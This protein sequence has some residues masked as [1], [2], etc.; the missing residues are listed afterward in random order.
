MFRSFYEVY[1]EVGDGFLD[2]GRKPEFKTFIICVN[3][4]LNN[5]NEII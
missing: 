2:F 1:N 5:Y 4:R 3:L